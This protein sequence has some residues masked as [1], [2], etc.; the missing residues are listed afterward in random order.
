MA[1]F[2]HSEMASIAEELQLTIPKPV[3]NRVVQ[4]QMSRVH[5]MIKVA[6]EDNSIFELH[7]HA[8]DRLE[9]FVKAF[10]ALTPEAVGSLST[11]E[12]FLE[13]HVESDWSDKLHFDN[14]L[15]NFGFSKEA[16]DKLRKMKY[17]W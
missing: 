4:R 14:L 2:D 3:L 7:A 11:W 17:T 12:G 1:L 5:E 16:A 8:I 15:D 13:E 10:E 6:R 9:K